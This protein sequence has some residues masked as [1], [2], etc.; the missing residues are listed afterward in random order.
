MGTGMGRRSLAGSLKPALRSHPPPRS[1]TPTFPDLNLG[2]VPIA[3]TLTTELGLQ[4]ELGG[5]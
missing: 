1:P 3:S 5:P 4:L 2:R